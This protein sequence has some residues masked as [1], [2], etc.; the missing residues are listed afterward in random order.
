MFIIIAGGGRV[1]YYLLKELLDR[2]QEVI[3]IERDKDRAKSIISEF[4][5]LVIIGDACDPRILEKAG[6]RRADMIIANTGEDED[7]FV[8]CQ[9]ARKK[10]RVPNSVAR[11]NNPQN[12]EIFK[13]LGIDS[14]VSATESILSVVEK[15]FGHGGNLIPIFQDGKMEILQTRI[16]RNT[17]VFG[18]KLQDL[19][20]PEKCVISAI[21]RSGELVQPSPDF[22]FKANDTIIIASSLP[23]IEKLKLIFATKG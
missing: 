9:I 17:A 20:L 12:D 10:F 23:G 6:I 14:T 11:V 1:G 5:N 8:I 22:E 3:L 21:I 16:T 7:N 2:A 19:E 13:K 18:S 4:G 15:K